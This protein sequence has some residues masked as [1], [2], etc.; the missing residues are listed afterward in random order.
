[1]WQSISFPYLEGPLSLE[2][3]AFSEEMFCEKDSI[4]I[5][6]GRTWKVEVKGIIL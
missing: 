2:E 4:Q 6:Y 3:K 1:M 5:A